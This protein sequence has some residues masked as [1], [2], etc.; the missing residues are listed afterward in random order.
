MKYL[1][2]LFILLFTGCKTTNVYV[3]AQDGDVRVDVSQQ[4]SDVKAKAATP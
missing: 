1:A 4:G 3:N 2:V